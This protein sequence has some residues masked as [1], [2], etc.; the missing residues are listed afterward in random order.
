MHKLM[1]IIKDNNGTIADVSTD[2]VTCIFKDDKCPFEFDG[3]DIKGYYFDDAQ[4]FPRYKIE[5]EGE[6]ERLQ[7]EILPKYKRIDKY[8][9][10]MPIFT[11][12]EDVEDNDF[13]PLIDKILSSNNSFHIDGRAGCGQNVT[14]RNEKSKDKVQKFSANK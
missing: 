10:S 2:C 9:H 7:I 11:V 14:K 3:K 1:Q 13:K 4:K 5:H 6:N 8:K 12:H